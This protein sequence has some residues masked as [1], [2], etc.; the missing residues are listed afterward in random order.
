M[1]VTTDP[2]DE[3]FSAEPRRV[4]LNDKEVPDWRVADEFRRVVILADGSVRNGAVCIERVASDRPAAPAPE[5]QAPVHDAGFV[6]MFAHVP[7]APVAAPAEPAPESAPEP[8]PDAPVEHAGP[9]A[10]SHDA[11]Q[12]DPQP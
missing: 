7:D 11:P 12:D 8:A 9:A 2:A 4:W 10:E 5:P 3:H 1:R 6:G